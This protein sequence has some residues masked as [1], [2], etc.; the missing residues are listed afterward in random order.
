VLSASAAIG[1][2]A[3]GLR[4][5]LRE[6]AVARGSG[7]TIGSAV[8]AVCLGWTALRGTPSAVG[9]GIAWFLTM[10]TALALAGLPPLLRRRF[11]PVSDSRAAR[12]LRAT[13]CASA[14]TLVV[15]LADL[16]RAT[17]AG[18]HPSQPSQQ[19]WLLVPW[20][21]FLLLLAGYVAVVIAVTAQR[22]WVTSPTLV[23][24]TR[25]GILL[26]VTMYAIMPLGF[27]RH[28]TAPWLPGARI[29]PLVA[30]AWVLLLFGPLTAA[31]SAGWRCRGPV[32][33]LPA[34]E[35]RIRQGIAAGVLVTLVGSVVVCVLGP[36]TLALLPDA[37]WLVHLLYP[38]QHVS[39]ARV[40]HRA[41]LLDTNGAPGYFLIW[42]TFPVVGLAIAA[43]TSLAAFGNQSARQREQG[44]VRPVA[45]TGRR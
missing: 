3:G 10:T 32:G 2:A 14:V 13:V 29:D 42:L 37:G 22:S 9:T 21:V 4:L 17:D 34:A 36:V 1:R 19:G 31:L 26:G 16:S 18:A 35:A 24:G 11:G 41:Y 43:L 28:A 40:A 23:L 44:P 7:K 33:E 38:G 20:S 15:T 6:S 12:W 39:P 30:A 45:G 8:A 25:V 27:G 5:I